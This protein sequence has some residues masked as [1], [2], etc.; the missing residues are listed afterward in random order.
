MKILQEKKALGNH[1]AKIDNEIT[2]CSNQK[3][4]N[5]Q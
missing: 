3:I 1:Y 5:K 2:K 4:K